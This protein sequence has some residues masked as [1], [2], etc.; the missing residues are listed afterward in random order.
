M[1]V[2]AINTTLSSK[3]NCFS[4]SSRSKPTTVP[5]LIGWYGI[6][7]AIES[8][9]GNDTRDQREH[10][11]FI[12]QQYGAVKGLGMDRF[13]YLLSA[14]QPSLQ[15]L[16]QIDNLLRLNFM[17]HVVSVTLVAVD[18]TVIEYQPGQSAKKQAE[19]RGTPIPV[20]FIPRKP[21]PNGLLLYQ[22]VTMVDSPINNG[23]LPFILDIIP[24]LKQGDSVPASS[25]QLI[26][27]RW[28]N[29]EKPHFLADAAF[30]SLDMLQ[31]VSN[32]GGKA[33]FSCSLNNL[34]FIIF[35]FF[36]F[37]FRTNFKRL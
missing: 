35:H 22:A 29:N 33:T 15:Q 26:M 16:E 18:E 4:N 31:I 20:V 12:K 36:F 7:I 11:S 17:D 25:F 21:H 10:F 5:E 14:L 30:G 24:H 13:G 6:F 3:D 2:N 37:E 8:S 28:N 19:E 23:T 32:W 34:D 9:Y 1:L 27:N